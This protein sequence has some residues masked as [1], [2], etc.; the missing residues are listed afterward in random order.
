MI[1]IKHTDTSQPVPINLMT[2]EDLV[3]A[4]TQKLKS[5]H[6]PIVGG[7]DINAMENVVAKVN[8]Q[9]DQSASA[10]EDLLLLAYGCVI[11]AMA[12]RIIKGGV[13]YLNP[14]TQKPVFLLGRPFLIR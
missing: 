7:K 11:D 14:F 5:E 10:M 9:D 1:I 6:Q 12:A 13:L 2:F 8:A 4:I 3:G